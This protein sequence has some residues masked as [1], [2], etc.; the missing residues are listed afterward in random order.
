MLV[1]PSDREKNSGFGIERGFK[2]F[3][4][5]HLPREGVALKV[6]VKIEQKKRG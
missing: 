1:R 5:S 3:L 6:K 2:P 4:L